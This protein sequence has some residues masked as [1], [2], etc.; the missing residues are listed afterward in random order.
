MSI[1]HNV[2]VYPVYNTIVQVHRVLTEREF[3]TEGEARDWAE[4]HNARVSGRA[5]A[6][7]TGAI[8]AETGENL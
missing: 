3:S 5:H 1:V 2:Q 7:Y 8:D 4:L 6:V